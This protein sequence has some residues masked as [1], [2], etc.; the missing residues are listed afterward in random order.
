MICP[1]N[2]TQGDADGAGDKEDGGAE[3]KEN[4]QNQ[5]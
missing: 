2:D 3:E 4:E 1:E 5:P